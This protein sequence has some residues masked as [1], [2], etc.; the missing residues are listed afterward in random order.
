VLDADDDATH[1][2][3]SRV[4]SGA[5]DH[6]SGATLGSFGLGSDGG[7]EVIGM[8]RFMHVFVA[9][10]TIAH[11]TLSKETVRYRSVSFRHFA[12]RKLW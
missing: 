7:S 9:L 2:S 10:S 6:L 4:V 12:Q 1:D 5:W 3:C 11:Q 8:P